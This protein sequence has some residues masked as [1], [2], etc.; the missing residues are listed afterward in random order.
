MSASV[1]TLREIF[2]DPTIPIRR[3]VEAAE[4]ILTFESP[5]PVAEDAKAFLAEVSE[6]EDQ[7]AD[8]R[9]SALKITRKLEA[10]RITQPILSPAEAHRNREAWRRKAIEERKQELVVM[11]L[12]P[13]PSDWADDLLDPAW[14]APPGLAN[15]PIDA[16]GFGDRMQAYRMAMKANGELKP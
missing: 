5:A 15:P 1:L 2:L 3:R 10:H 6:D 7:H 9:I 12:W 14:I 4:A 11:G 8:V 16:T 13:A